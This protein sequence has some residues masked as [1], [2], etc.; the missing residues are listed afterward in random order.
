MPGEDGAEYSEDFEV[1]D[2]LQDEGMQRSEEDSKGMQRSEDNSREE[3]E[4][5][6]YEKVSLHAP[7]VWSSYAHQVK[8]TCIMH[9]DQ[10]H[11]NASN[12]WKGWIR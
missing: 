8:I 9:E 10:M 5:V 3:E 11:G 12:G 7:T 6:D 4:E 2:S 1:Y